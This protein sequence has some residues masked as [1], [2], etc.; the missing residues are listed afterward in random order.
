M[1]ESFDEQS[2]IQGSRLV[3]RKILKECLLNLGYEENHFPNNAWILER[4]DTIQVLRRVC[5][6][7][8][9]NDWETNLDLSNVIEKHLETH[10]HNNDK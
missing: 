1:A 10:L 8:G 2:Y 4:E 3:W 7:F 6:K 5:D 9:D